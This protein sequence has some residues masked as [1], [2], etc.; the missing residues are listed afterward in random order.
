M[1]REEKPL[2]CDFFRD[3]FDSIRNSREKIFYVTQ[4]DNCPKS[5]SCKHTNTHTRTEYYAETCVLASVTYNTAS[6]KDKQTFIKTLLCYVL[7]I[8][9]FSALTSPFSQDIPICMYLQ[10]FFF[11]FCASTSELAL[12]ETSMPTRKTRKG[13]RFRSS[14]NIED[15]LALS[16]I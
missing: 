12:T 4:C 10:R 5:S 16:T 1:T 7:H 3:T 2:S 11:G 15:C 9:D 8:F 13:E 6:L 14:A